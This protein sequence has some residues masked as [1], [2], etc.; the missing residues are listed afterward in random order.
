MAAPKLRNPAEIPL[1]VASVVINL[2]IV[3]GIIYSAWVLW[4][5]P[6]ELQDT[7][8]AATARV[9]LAGLLLLIPG[10]V[11]WRELTRAS[12]RGST[13]QL[14]R[15][16]FPEIYATMERFAQELQLRRGQWRAQCLCRLRVRVRLR[17]HQQRALRRPLPGQPGRA[18]FHHRARIGA[19]QARAHIPVVPALDRLHRPHSATGGLPL[20]RSRIF[21]RPARGTSLSARRGGTTPA[22]G[23]PLRPQPGQHRRTVDPGR[24]VPGLLGG[25][26]PATFVPP[27]HREPG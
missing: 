24:A 27:V 8:W 15:A 16:Q 2:A 10:L 21:L 12:T 23:G 4:W 18:G 11:L 5:L 14:S 7:A 22:D 17:R 19:H 25:G 1:Y 9:G 20:A 26:S 6:E 13:V 3:A